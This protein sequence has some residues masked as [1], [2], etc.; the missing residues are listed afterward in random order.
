M[1]SIERDLRNH[2]T[3]PNIST[4]VEFSDRL[5][6]ALICR[7]HIGVHAVDR[8][9]GSVGVWASPLFKIEFGEVLAADLAPAKLKES[10]R[11]TAEAKRF[12]DRSA[13]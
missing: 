9:I 11:L 13:Q 3:D 8:R 2:A 1:I 6:E 7:E 12:A 10:K 5:H 4:I